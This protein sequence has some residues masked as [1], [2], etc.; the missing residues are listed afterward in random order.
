MAMKVRFRTVDTQR[1]ETLPPLGGF[2]ILRDNDGDY[3]LDT[4]YSDRHDWIWGNE[5]C[6]G[7]ADGEQY[8]VLDEDGLE[9]MWRAVDT[10][11]MAALP[12]EGALCLLKI[13]EDGR[14]NWHVGHLGTCD[15]A[16][17]DDDGEERD[18]EIL[19]WCD[20]WVNIR[21]EYY[22][23]YGMEL[24]VQNGDMYIP[25]EVEAEE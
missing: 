9:G 8:A 22:D 17:E 19:S 12:G 13:Q 16:D 5:L 2:C 25:L 23:K 15:A 11:D 14:W 6:P 20:S 18:V 10:K 4:V 3:W 7:V 21:E 1:P 24:A